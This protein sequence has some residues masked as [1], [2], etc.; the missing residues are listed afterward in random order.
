[1]TTNLLALCDWV[2]S[3]GVTHVAM[4]ST[5][6]YW[7]PIYNLMEDRFHLLLLNAQHIKA[8]PGRKTDVRDSEWIADLLRHGLLKA[9]FV[10]DRYHRELRAL[11]RQRTALVEERSGVANWLQKSLEE[12]NIKLASVASSIL[13]KSARE[14]LEAL[15][16]GTM[17]P[18]TMAELA[19]ERLRRKIPQ[20]EQAL[21]GSVGAHEKFLVALF[22]SHIDFLDEAV[23]QVSVRI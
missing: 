20:L 22:L 4:E 16:A 8:V 14:M 10:P 23:Q 6:V 21:L 15:V 3:K 5:G 18:A 17:D 1:M 13:G 7:Q 11:T 2:T 12:A 9:S 19:K